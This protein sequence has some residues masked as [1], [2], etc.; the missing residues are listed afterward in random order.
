VTDIIDSVPKETDAQQLA[1][2]LVVL[3]ELVVFL[4]GP[5]TTTGIAWT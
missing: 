4:N 1:A 2:E 5:A 3:A